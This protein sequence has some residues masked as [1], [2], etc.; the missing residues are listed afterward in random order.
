MESLLPT[1]RVPL[2]P[3]PKVCGVPSD[4]LD[5]RFSGTLVGRKDQEEEVQVL[6][7]KGTVGESERVG[8]EGRKEGN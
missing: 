5:V 1:S 8:E 6:R 7:V 4:G 3:R 2:S